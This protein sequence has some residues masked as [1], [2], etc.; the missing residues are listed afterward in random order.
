MPPVRKKY[1][2]NLLFLAAILAFMSSWTGCGEKD[3][4]I[5]E[6]KIMPTDEITRVMEAHVDEL[7][8]VPGVTGVAIGALENGEL[9]I[10]VLVVKDTPELRNRIPKELGGYPV[11]IEE[12]GEIRALPGENE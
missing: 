8:A 10:K 6:E 1:V 4:T 9:C 2:I 12:T 3:R 5:R 7:M 11:I